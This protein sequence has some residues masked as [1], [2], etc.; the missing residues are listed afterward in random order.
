MPQPLVTLT[1]IKLY[2]CL[3]GLSV[4]IPFEHEYRY[5]D[6]FLTHPSATC[7]FYSGVLDH[8]ANFCI[9]ATNIYSVIPSLPCPVQAVD[10]NYESLH[11]THPI[12]LFLLADCI[13]KTSKHTSQNMLLLLSTNLCKYHCSLNPASGIAYHDEDDCIV[14]YFTDVPAI[15]SGET[16]FFPIVD[17]KSHILSIHKSKGNS[18]EDILKAFQE[19]VIKYGYPRCL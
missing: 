4:P 5:T 17:H 1:S 7:C 3:A 10:Y 12:F 18:E 6:T 13:R 9:N 15:D 8:C 14:E 19:R 11:P 16:S 2:N